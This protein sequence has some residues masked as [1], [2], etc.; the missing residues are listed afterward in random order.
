MNLLIFF[1]AILLTLSV[2]I[3]VVI[4]FFTLLLINKPNLTISFTILG[5]I[6]TSL[7]FTKS[8]YDYLK[9]QNVITE[10]TDSEWRVSKDGL[11]IKDK[12]VDTS[13]LNHVYSDDDSDI[14]SH[15]IYVCSEDN[16]VNLTY[17]KYDLKIQTQLTP[18][19]RRVG[20]TYKS[21]QDSEDARQRRAARM[22]A[23]GKPWYECLSPKKN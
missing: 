18:P 4:T 15:P 3:F 17:K 14:L 23:T 20:R 7:I 9:N 6:I 19:K 13:D 21:W 5:G 16:D 10:N 2:I 11:I 1:N 22:A 8:Y 12:S